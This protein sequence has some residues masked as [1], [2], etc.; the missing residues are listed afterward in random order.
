MISKIIVLIGIMSGSSLG[1]WLGGKIGIMTAVF[2]GSI[3]A[4]AG[5]YFSR[6]FVKNYLDF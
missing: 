4:A 1:W 2:G 3:G 5:L 6:Q